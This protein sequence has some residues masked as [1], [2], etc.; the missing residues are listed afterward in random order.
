MPGLTIIRATAV[1]G[2]H[3]GIP[4]PQACLVL[5]GSKEVTQA[6]VPRYSMQGIR[7]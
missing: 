3:H 4:H 2:L 5:Q 7:C 6:S 1:S